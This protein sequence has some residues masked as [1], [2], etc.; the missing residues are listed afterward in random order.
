MNQVPATRKHEGSAYGNSGLWY[1][2][3]PALKFV[4]RTDY[5]GM[6]FNPDEETE[7]LTLEEFVE[8]SLRYAAERK[9]PYIPGVKN[10]YYY[11]NI[12]GEVFRQAGPVDTDAWGAFELTPAEY[13]DLSILYNQNPDD[14]LL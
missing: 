3:W 9:T 1:Y 14:T 12:Y 10:Q 6:K 5:D 11:C 8:L 13:I 2:H 4:F 7:E